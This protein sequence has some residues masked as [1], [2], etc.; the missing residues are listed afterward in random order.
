MLTKLKPKSEFSRNVLTLMTGTS[1][2]QA[3]PIVIS[4]I[5]TRIYSPD[6]FGVLALYLALYTFIGIIATARYEVTIVLPKNDN[7]AINIVSLAIV[8]T[9]IMSLVTLFLILLFGDI[10]VEVFNAPSLDKW[11]YFIPVSV[12]LTGLYQTFNYWN[13]RKKRYKSIAISRISQSSSTAIVNLSVGY[14]G[15]SSYGLVSGQIIGQLFSTLVLLRDMIFMNRISLKSISLNRMIANAK[16][17]KKFPLI[18]SFHAFMDVLQSSGIVF[19]I[20]FIFSSLIVGFYSMTMRIMGAP[21]SLIGSAMS[22]VYYQKA[23]SIVNEK[24]DLFP[25]TKNMMIRLFIIAFPFMLIIIFFGESLFKI[26]LGENWA[27]AGVYAQ[28]LSPYFFFKF[29]ISPVSSLPNILDRQG[30]FFIFTFFGNI[31]MLGSIF[32]GG[33]LMNSIET[34]FLILSISMS[35]Y[36]TTLL[37]WLLKI[38]KLKQIG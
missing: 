36:F 17:Y 2:A 35:I 28:L 8:I 7:D 11:L 20:S 34:A 9:V 22:Q 3:I 25:L 27:V 26:L 37:V 1:I 4:P 24:G 31:L 12:F 10:I 21:I 14:S 16:R 5:L 38:S 19:I 13:I 29:I 6:E 32:I 15:F 33:I 23:S 30:T 18:N